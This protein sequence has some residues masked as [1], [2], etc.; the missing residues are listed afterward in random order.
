MG[1]IFLIS[2]NCDFLLK[3]LTRQ[4]DQKATVAVRPI[5]NRNG[6]TKTVQLQA[7]AGNRTYYTGVVNHF[8]GNIPLS[9]TQQ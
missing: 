9:R 8:S 2:Q 6:F 7:A 5:H 3:K 4:I 1:K